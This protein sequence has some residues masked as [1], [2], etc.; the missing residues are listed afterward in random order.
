MLLKKD[1]IKLFVYDFDGVMTDNR[2]LVS[3]DGHEAVFCNRSDGM[4]VIK[5][6][7]LGLQQVII[8]TE[9]NPVVSMRAKKLGI[10]VLQGIEDKATVLKKYCEKLKVS[11][12]DVLYVGNDIN[13][14]DAMKL[15]GIGVSPADGDESIKKISKI[16]TKA[17]GGYG[18]IR[19][20]YK[21][22]TGF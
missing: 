7:K 14:L 6:K 20:L 16:I 21:M 4:A 12:K 9:T 3:D 2:V 17:K 11:L 18:V 5:I 13:D 19:E 8:S 1:K 10:E 22:M 15:V